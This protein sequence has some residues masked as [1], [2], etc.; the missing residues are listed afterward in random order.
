MNNKKNTGLRRNRFLLYFLIGFLVTALDFLGEINNGDYILE[1]EIFFAVLTLPSIVVVTYL[2]YYLRKWIMNTGY[3]RNIRV[4]GGYHQ[5]LFWGVVILAKVIGITFFTRYLSTL[6]LPEFDSG[7]FFDL[8]FLGIFI[9][10]SFVALFVHALESFSELQRENQQVQIRLRD[11]ENEK[12]IAKFLNLKNQLNPHFLFNSFNS[13]SG[14]ITQDPEKAEYFLN[15]LSKVYR[16]T[17][18]QSDELVVPLS[19]EL[20]LM[21]S[22]VALQQI[23][24]NKSLV[25]DYNVAASDLDKMVP[26]MTLELLV[27]NAIKHNIVEKER[28]L[29]ITVRT[30][31]NYVIVSN[32]YQPR[33][34]S[35]KHGES[36]GKGL[37]NLTNQYTM[38]HTEKPKFEIKNGKYVAIVP[39]IEST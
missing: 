35:N 32:N 10:L 39:L 9:G 16:Y 20:E 34:D 29:E 27:E 18:D 33:N 3:Y 5:R 11:I 31:G 2:F 15:E 26:P 24:F 23:R 4:K 30:L 37:M 6:M 22:Y 38:I 14:L 17:L 12:L 36:T 8:L 7:D 21:R 28:P 13:L 25:V 19:K 1:E